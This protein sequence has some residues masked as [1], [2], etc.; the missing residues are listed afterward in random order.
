MELRAM[1]VLGK[2]SMLSHTLAPHWGTL[3]NALADRIHLLKSP[4]SPKI[5]LPPFQMVSLLCVCVWGWGGGISGSDHNNR[6]T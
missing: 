5:A 2:N 4:K 6:K 3:A 1:H